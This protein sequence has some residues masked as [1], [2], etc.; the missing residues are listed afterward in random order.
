[1]NYIHLTDCETNSTVAVNCKN[2]S[3]VKEHEKYTIII[4]GSN[5]VLFVKEDYLDVV[6]RLNNPGY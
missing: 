4:F 6:S 5:H 2:V 1:M 3:M